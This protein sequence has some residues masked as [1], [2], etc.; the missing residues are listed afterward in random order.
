MD[1]SVVHVPCADAHA[2]KTV[3]WEVGAVLGA[4]L[5]GGSSSWE[6]K[7][8]R[9]YA[10]CNIHRSGHGASG[11]V[12]HLQL[13][14][15]AIHRDTCMRSDRL[16]KCRMIHATRCRLPCVSG[17]CASPPLA[18]AENIS[19]CGMW[20]PGT[21]RCKPVRNDATCQAYV[22]NIDF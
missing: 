19:R 12:H 7:M 11:A 1:K 22:S 2:H 18:F 20:L 10:Q 4:L 6:L 16:A 8:K 14:T 3:P 21:Q 5:G 9:R 17:R 13:Y 15:T